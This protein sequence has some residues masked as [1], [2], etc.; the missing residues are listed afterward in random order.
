MDYINNVVV[1]DL[2]TNES[3]FYSKESFIQKFNIKSLFI[4][5]SIFES[6]DYEP[7]PKQRESKKLLDF[8]GITQ[9]L[10]SKSKYDYSATTYYLGDY[11]CTLL[12]IVDDIGDLADITINDSIL[13]E[14]IR[15]GYWLCENDGD[16]SI[17]YNAFEFFSVDD[18]IF[19][20]E[21]QTLGDYY[22]FATRDLIKYLQDKHNCQIYLNF[23]SF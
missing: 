22:S 1:L 9:D 14:I 15:D 23:K 4:E 2:G 18:L 21:T 20:G 11:Y 8:L 6:D 10:L 3:N 17:S 19:S 13:S 12:N 5:G 16:D 7:S